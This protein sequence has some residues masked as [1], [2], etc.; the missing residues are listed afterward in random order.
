[1]RDLYGEIPQQIS[2]ILT[3]TK[4]T[5]VASLHPSRERLTI[6]AEHHRFAP[7]DPPAPRA[8]RSR[9]RAPQLYMREQIDWGYSHVAARA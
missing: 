7:G 4:E 5:N 9:S 6:H 8:W 2:T 3:L 1:L